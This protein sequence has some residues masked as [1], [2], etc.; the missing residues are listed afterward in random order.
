MLVT[1]GSLSLSAQ[2]ATTVFGAVLSILATIWLRARTLARLELVLKSR[3]R[4]EWFYAL[5]FWA[6][7][8]LL[9]VTYNAAALMPRRAA[10]GLTAGSTLLVLGVVWPPYMMEARL[11]STQRLLQRA[12]VVAVGAILLSLGIGHGG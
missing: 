4:C 10:V 1:P 7:A 3:N 11:T 9:G 8:V 12:T 5:V 2:I 6:L